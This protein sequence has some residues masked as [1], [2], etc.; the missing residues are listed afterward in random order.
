MECPSCGTVTSDGTGS[1]DACGAVL[2]AAEEPNLDPLAGGRFRIRANIGEGTRKLVYLAHDEFLDRPVAIAVA[3]AEGFDE[4]ELER[5]RREIRMLGRLSSH[6][7]VV[8]LY[9]VTQLDGATALLFEYVPGGSVADLLALAGVPLPIRDALRIAEQVAWALDGI[10][11]EGI[12]FRDVKT[13]NVLLVG[14]GTAKL[15]DF[16]LALAP[17]DGRLTDEHIVMGSLSYLAP[18]RVARRHYD[19]RSDLYSLGAVLYE[20]LAGDPP[21]PGDDVNEVGAQILH[22]EP[23]PLLEARPDLP[24]ALS[25]LVMRLLAKDVGQRPDSAAEVARAIA[26]FPR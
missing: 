12:I 26:A 22:A 9:D 21:F 8:T 25:E 5:L 13:A 19:H 18:E 15:C 14:D 23:P 10:H 17:G 16:G 24:E 4:R 7:N 1:C 2:P 3:R 6:P 20:M 11:R